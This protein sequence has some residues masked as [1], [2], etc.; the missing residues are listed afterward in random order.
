MD[1]AIARKA[2]LAEGYLAAIA[3]IEGVSFVD[4]PNFSQS[5]HWLNALTLDGATMDDRDVVLDLL[6]D[7]NYMSRPI[8]T[9]CHRLP[10][11]ASAPAAP[12]PV[13]TRLER[14]VINIPSSAQLSVL[15]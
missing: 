7:A 3:S 5:N 15:P 14:E 6:N 2:L 12:L 10:M 8:W 9:L 1:D 11:N 13:A 4:A